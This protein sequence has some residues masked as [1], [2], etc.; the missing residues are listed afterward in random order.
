MCPYTYNLSGAG[1]RDRRLVAV[2]AGLVRGYVPKK[3]IR[4]SRILYI[5][6]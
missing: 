6:L 1:D 4:Q 5:L 3:G 2:S